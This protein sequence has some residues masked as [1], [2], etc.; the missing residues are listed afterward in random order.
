MSVGRILAAAA[1]ITATTLTGCKKKPEV[2]DYGRP[3]PFGQN[4]LRKITNPAEL[5]DLTAAFTGRDADLLAALDGSI[6]WYSKPS[7]QQFFPSNGI[8][9]AQAKASACAFRQILASSANSAAFQQAIREQF[10][11]YISVGWDNRG[12]V[13]YTGYYSPIF[14]ASKT[15]TAEYRF[16]LYQRPPDLVSDPVTG[17]VLGRRSGDSVVPYPT[18]SQIESMGPAALGLAG[19]E[20]VWLKDKLDAYLIHVN[21]S[22]KLRLPSGQFMYVGFAG[23][24][25]HEYTSVG[26]MLVKEG[27]IPANRLGLPTIREYFRGRPNELDSYLLRND[28]YVFFKE[29]DPESW[30]AGSLGVR[31]TP[32]RSIAT[33]KDIFPRAAAVLIQTTV[34]AAGYPSGRRHEAF[35]CDQDTGGAIRAAG[36]S[37]IYMGVGP[38]AEQIAGRQAAEGRLYYF[39]LKPQYV[40]R[41]AAPAPTAKPLPAEPAEANGSTD[42]PFDK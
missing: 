24:N 28:R 15:Q 14:E 8:S 12:T 33:D 19:R 26:R 21:G 1:L 25:G 4:A 41:Y 29:Y 7:S 18:R 13:Y 11:T 22:A 10:D 3:L 2:P 23:T 39:F 38:N 40:S 5:P 16:P 6:A 17:K 35:A 31:V 37:D 9:H 20:L 30:P 34:P 36:R 42:Q 32:W 27:K